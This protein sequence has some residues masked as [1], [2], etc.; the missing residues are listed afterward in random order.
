MPIILMPTS[1]KDHHFVVDS[2]LAVCVLAFLSVD[3]Y[4]TA[5]GGWL[6]VENAKG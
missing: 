5:S 1:L 2:Y 3:L 4:F 6:W